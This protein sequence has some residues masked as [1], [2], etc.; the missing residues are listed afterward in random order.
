MQNLLK[1][2]L[3]ARPSQGLK[4][5]RNHGEWFRAL[6]NADLAGLVP[7]HYL[8]IAT[9]EGRMPEFTTSMVQ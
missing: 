4:N 9:P 8:Q 6:C 5:L 2:I 7:H 3:S 1:V